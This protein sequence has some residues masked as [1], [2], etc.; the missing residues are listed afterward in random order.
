MRKILISLISL[1]FFLFPS[2]ANA[3]PIR[4]TPVNFEQV[5][6][7]QASEYIGVRYCRG[8]TT[9]RCFDCSGFTQYIYE[10]QGIYLDRRT[11]VQYKESTI[12]SKEEAKPGDLVFFLNSSGYAYHVGIYV[13]ENK[14]LHSPKPGRSVKIETIWSKRVKFATVSPIDKP[15]SI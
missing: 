1:S 8:G 10:K 3:A 9:P 5:I 6:I 14:I 11:H 15:E 4:E 13:G 12:I 7:D 2:A